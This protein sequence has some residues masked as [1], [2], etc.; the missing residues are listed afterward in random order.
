MNN[1]TAKTDKWLF[2]QWEFW[3]DRGILK[4]QQTEHILSP[5]LNQVLELLISRAPSLVSRETFLDEVWKDKFVNEGALSRSIAELRKLLGD[6]AAQ[7]KYIKTFPKKGY[8]FVAIAETDS[9]KKTKNY[10]KIAAGL[11]LMALLVFIIWP[12]QESVLNR[13]QTMVAGAQRVTFQPGM[14]QQSVLSDDGEQIAYVSFDNAFSEVV[15]SNLT[16][17][18]QSRR[19][20]LSGFNLASP[21][22]IEEQQ[23]II[24][25]AEQGGACQL[26]QYDLKTQHFEALADC[27]YNGESRT[28]DWHQSLQSVFYSARDDDQKVAIHQFDFLKNSSQLVTQPPSASEQDWSPKI[29]PNSQWLSFSRGNQNVRNLWLKNLSS[30]EEWPLTEGEHYSVSHDWFDD[31]HLLFD[32]DMN[33]S[34]Q[35]WLM[36]INEK[37]A[38][39]VGA[40]GA[41]HPSFDMAHQIMTYQEVSYEA[42]IWLFDT[43]SQSMARVIHSTKYDNNPAFSPDGQKFVFSSNRQDIGSIWLYDMETGIE[44]LL[45]TLPKTKL[46]RPHWDETGK[47]VVI[48]SNNSEGYGSLVINVETKE[49]QV[50][51]FKQANS[52][53]LLWGDVVYAL[54]KSKHNKGQILRLK[55]GVETALPVEG[56]SRFMV[57]SN[58]DFVYT[59][60]DQDGIYRFNRKALKEQLLI[61]HFNHKKFNLWTA[62]NQSIYYDQSGQYAGLWRYDIEA[63]SHELITQHRPSS[64]G[65][66]LSVNR[67]ENQVLITRTDRAE[68]DILKAQLS[69]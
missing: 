35:L 11:V 31:E 32:S 63:E 40:N 1:Q 68:S 56:V 61:A 39:L 13:L 14:E 64:V 36:N 34:R 16:D 12:K 38:M 23:S 5:Q 69:Q 41:Q 55:D 6:S 8:Q 20:S 22:F 21:D 17:T 65:S 10:K 30:G 37:Q 26:T 24:L 57:L 67:L 2:D 59:K 50:I 29:S 3:P 28:L 53:A 9:D 46:T 15:V 33:G 48:T 25:T 52:E 49:F 44:Q 60:S 27:V 18:N 42:N 43:E 47:R 19:I 4:N 45:L 62:V 54:S 66:A 51:P 7:A 58:G